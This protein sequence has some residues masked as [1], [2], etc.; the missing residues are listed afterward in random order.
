[1]DRADIVHENFL[2][3]VAGEGIGTRAIQA[4]RG[5]HGELAG[6]A[7]Q[8]RA[9]GQAAEDQLDGVV[10]ELLPPQHARLA[11]YHPAGSNARIGADP[12]DRAH[13]AAARA[14]AAVASSLF[15]ISARQE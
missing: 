10:G 2:R 15:S 7:E 13:G 12:G 1:M 14:R 6:A 3:R 11:T 9:A 5:E 8:R 4:G